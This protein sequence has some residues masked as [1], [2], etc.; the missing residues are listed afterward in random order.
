MLHLQSTAKNLVCAYF[1][2]IFLGV[3]MRAQETPSFHFD[4]SYSR[5]PPSAWKRASPYMIGF[6]VGAVFMSLLRG[7]ACASVQHQQQVSSHTS[8]HGGEAHSR[9]LLSLRPSASSRPASASPFPTADGEVAVAEDEGEGGA[10]VVDEGSEAAADEEESEAA[11]AEEN[12]EGSEAAADEESSEGS[13]AAAAEEKSE[14]SEAAADEESS[15]GS[16]AA[17]AEENSEPA[18]TAEAETDV[19]PPITAAEMEERCAVGPCRSG[20]GGR[21]SGLRSDWADI[22]PKPIMRSCTPAEAEAQAAWFDVERQ[23]YLTGKSAC[24][25]AHWMGDLRDV[26]YLQLL[27]TYKASLSNDDGGPASPPPPVMSR[28][29]LNI[30]ANKGYLSTSLLAHWKPWYGVTNQHLK[31]Y[32]DGAMPGKEENVKCGVCKDCHETAV[33]A[34][35]PRLAAEAGLTQAQASSP[36]LQSF[37]QSRLAMS[38]FAFEPTPSNFGLL[39]GYAT[40]LAKS[41]SVNHTGS[42]IPV[43]AGIANFTGTA[44][45]EERGAGDEGSSLGNVNKGDG[46]MVE[47][48][49]TTVDA[50][51]RERVD[52]SQEMIIDLNHIDTEGYDPAAI[53]GSAG[54]LPYTR[55]LGFEYHDLAM[56]QTTSLESVVASLDQQFGFDCYLE[57]GSMFVRLNGGCWHRNYEFKSWSNVLCVNRRDAEWA[58][59]IARKAT[60]WEAKGASRLRR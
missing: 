51:L 49:I 32:L 1:I 60:Q 10:I 9:P 15:E 33:G 53:A 55:L 31:S 27:K 11:A 12:S 44:Q 46:Q 4:G 52:P 24:A 39:Q 7:P 40:L 43:P 35:L 34:D 17:A 18:A 14:G 19:A 2:F 50:F 28:I 36:E 23:T 54:S 58:R 20:G 13:E 59:A 5:P 21:G 16:E 47:V 37:L 38:I 56:W 29:M 45:F 3:T 42:F 41:P 48:A 30:G 25:F 26:D 6:I 57:W 8:V 22:E